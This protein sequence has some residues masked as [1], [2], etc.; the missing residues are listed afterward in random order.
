VARS[1]TSRLRY[2][3]HYVPVLPFPV[4][5]VSA[6]VTRP[7][8]APQSLLRV[9]AHSVAA[10]ITVFLDGDLDLGSA[11]R[12]ARTVSRLLRDFPREVVVDVRG[13]RL[14]SPQGV[15]SLLGLHGRL[16]EAGVQVGLRGPNPRL[17][18][19]FELYGLKEILVLSEHSVDGSVHPS[20]APGWPPTGFRGSGPT[21]TVK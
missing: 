19:L 12:L 21:A 16:E 1:R 5:L 18:L 4:V 14:C 15:A 20:G 10:R 7:A 3:D 17:A 9:H 8:K 6:G 11:P 13:V 2:L